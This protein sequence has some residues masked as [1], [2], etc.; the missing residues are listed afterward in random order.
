[1]Y[2]TYTR[3][4]LLERRSYEKRARIK[5]MK[6]TA[7]LLCKGVRGAQNIV[8]IAFLSMFYDLGRH[9]LSLIDG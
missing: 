3:K 1:M 4:K 6:L 7:G 5:L 9:K 2:V 8:F